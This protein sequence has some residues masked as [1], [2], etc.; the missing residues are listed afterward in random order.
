[1]CRLLAHVSPQ[2]AVVADLIGEDGVRRYQDMAQLHDDGWGTMWVGD[3]DHDPDHTEHPV[4]RHRTPE[5]GLTA[6]RLSAVLTQEPARARVLHL[7][8]A[9]L[10]MANE[11]VNT[12]PFVQADLGLAHNG[13][14]VP[15]DRLRACVQR[16]V[17]PAVYDAI[18]GTTDSELY[19]GLVRH[20]VAGGASCLEA[21]MHAV[22]L[23]R[24]EFPRASLN[25]M[26]LTPQSL[27]VVHSS[28]QAP[29]PWHDFVAC[30]M[31][32]LPL[33]HDTQYFQLRY[34]RCPDGSLVVASTG[35]ETAGWH[36]LPHDTLLYVDLPTAR[37]EVIPLAGPSGRD[38]GA[39]PEGRA[40]S[41]AAHG[42][43]SVG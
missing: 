30:G 4:R 42:A 36:D 35:L 3:H 2:P 32:P 37:Y 22:R 33:G 28:A 43:V 16:V 20:A 39:V 21:T 17:P 41:E 24:S 34:R 8:L 11:E 23:I 29:V 18:E 15:A 9:T 27:V 7:R 25:A 26:V 38:R 19:F 31:D 6:A 40:R 5:S 13:A 1:M 10:T 14:I 12:H